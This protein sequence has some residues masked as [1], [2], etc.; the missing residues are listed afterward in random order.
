MSWLIT[1]IVL[2]ASI[3]I[4]A[5]RSLHRSRSIAV[6]GFSIA[7][8]GPLI[9]LLPLFDIEPR[10][11]LILWGFGLGTAPGSVTVSYLALRR[12]R[13]WDPGSGWAFIG[14]SIGSGWLLAA[15]GLV[16]A[17]WVPGGGK[18][19]DV[20]ALAIMR[21]ENWVLDT[22]DRNT[23]MILVLVGL[24]V[25]AA[26]VVLTSLLNR[27]RARGLE[28]LLSIS[29]MT[30]LISTVVLYS[31]LI[32]ILFDP[33][34]ESWIAHSALLSMGLVLVLPLALLGIALTIRKALTGSDPQ[35]RFKEFL[36]EIHM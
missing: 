30:M 18:F 33:P 14:L 11:L 27:I 4:A 32:S 3:T 23:E 6:V 15:A 21:V 36:E 16:I 12:I 29:W 2:C 28:D 7:V 35:A 34:P 10:V 5:L 26:M 1:G 17:T 24:V 19:M 8:A 22:N 25:N 13:A 20:V 9:A 31:G